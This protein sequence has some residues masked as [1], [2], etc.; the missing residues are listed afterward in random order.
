LTAKKEKVEGEKKREGKGGGNWQ[1]ICG[2]QGRQKIE[3]LRVWRKTKW[4][5][6]GADT[7]PPEHE[8]GKD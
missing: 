6:F 4:I 5:S 2:Q 1:K 8:R 7:L 3:K